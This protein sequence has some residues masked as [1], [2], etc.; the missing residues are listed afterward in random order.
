MLK[1]VVPLGKLIS[2]GEVK[3]AP[4]P[5]GNVAGAVELTTIEP[6]LLFVLKNAAGMFA[7]EYA[8]VSLFKSIR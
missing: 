1:V 5:N 3:I 2:V 6:V 8:D 7:K 4:S